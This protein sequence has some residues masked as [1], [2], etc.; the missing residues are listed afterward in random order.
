MPKGKGKA[1]A[2][3]ATTA[4]FETTVF[5]KLDKITDGAVRFKECTATGKPKATANA[6]FRTTYVRHE[7][8]DHDAEGELIVPDMIKCTYEAV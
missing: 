2:K 8:L 1:K 5:M 7:G 6:L 4:P 3:E